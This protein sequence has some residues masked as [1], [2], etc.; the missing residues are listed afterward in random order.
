MRVVVRDNGRG[1]DAATRDR[2]G[3]AFFTRRPGGTGLGVA[4]ARRVLAL[5]GA[6]LAYTSRPGDGTEAVVTFAEAG[7]A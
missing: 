7:G 6:T 5:H 4:H 2:V 1:M 3:T